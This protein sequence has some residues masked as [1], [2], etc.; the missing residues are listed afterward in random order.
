MAVST[1]PRTYESVGLGQLWFGVA[2]GPVLWALYHMLVYGAS[3]LACKWGWLTGT[4][5]L[6]M[7]AARLLMVAMTLLF[8]AI[9]AYAGFLS[10][11]AWKRLRGE[12]HDR[13][14]QRHSSESE[15]STEPAGRFR[16]M[17]LS[18]VL[19]SGL[20]AVTILMNVFPVLMLDLCAT[21]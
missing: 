18:G 21:Q 15:R 7:S 6:G 8:T 2:G 10:F 12:E 4:V 5:I 1:E 11:G 3:S 16:F 20:F 19:L 14:D 9:V 13:R 17:A